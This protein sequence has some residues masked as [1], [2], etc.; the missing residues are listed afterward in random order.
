[1]RHI[2]TSTCESATHLPPHHHTLPLSLANVRRAWSAWGVSPRPPCHRHYPLSLANARWVVLSLGQRLATTTPSHSQMRV[3]GDSLFTL[4]ETAATSPPPQSPPRSQA[5]GGVLPASLRHNCGCGLTTEGP[6][7][8][9]CLSSLANGSPTG[10]WRMAATLS[11]SQVRVGGGSAFNRD[12]CHV[13]TTILPS[14]PSPPPSHRA[15]RHTWPGPSAR[16]QRA[17]R[18]P[19][20]HHRHHPVRPASPGARAQRACR[21]RHHHHHPVPP[22]S[23]T[24][25]CR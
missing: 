17:C 16:A 14:S 11:R 8:F 21:G 25:T 19:R 13:T 20:H 22:S 3:G 23:P 15:A 5:R 18:G 1:V 10:L 24:V 2:T 6:F 9:F 4:P 12:S 7:L